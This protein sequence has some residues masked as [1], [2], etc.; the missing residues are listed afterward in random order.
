VLSKTNYGFLLKT[1]NA[2]GEDNFD[3]VL[4]SGRGGD[5]IDMVIAIKFLF[6][7]IGNESG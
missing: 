1:C 3:W 2:R 6:L 4:G 5:V 7:T